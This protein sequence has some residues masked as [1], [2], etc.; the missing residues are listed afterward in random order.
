MIDKRADMAYSDIGHIGAILGLS[1]KVYKKLT[2][3][4]ILAQK[5]IGLGYVSTGTY[6]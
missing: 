2:P 6:I 4:I 1:I 3:K 5:V